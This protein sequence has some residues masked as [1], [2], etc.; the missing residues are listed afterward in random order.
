MLLKGLVLDA[1]THEAIKDVRVE[2]EN[3]QKASI[4]DKNGVYVIPI[5]HLPVKLIFSNMAYEKQ[6]QWIN[7][8][9]FLNV[10]LAMKINYMNE[11]A[12]YS[13]PMVAKL[14]INKKLWALDYEFSGD[15]ILL[16]VKENLVFGK[17][18]LLLINENADSITSTV[19]PNGHEKLIKDCE[20]NIYVIAKYEVSMLSIS[21]NHILLFPPMSMAEYSKTIEPCVESLYGNYYFKELFAENYAINYCVHEKG[22]IKA[23][24]FKTIVD[25][26][27][28][29][30]YRAEQEHLASITDPFDLFVEE[31]YASKILFKPINAPLLSDNKQL[32]VFNFTQDRIE[33]YSLNGK[34]N[35]IVE[36]D[37]HKNKRWGNKILKDEFTGFFYTYY[38]K[39]GKYWVN[40]I[41]LQNGELFESI[42]I[43][44]HIFIDDIKIYH[45][46]L[47]FLYR[48]R[49]SYDNLALYAMKLKII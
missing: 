46:T 26:Q 2:I 5:N 38:E 10:Q 48:D 28:I 39:A 11:I 16:L 29:R 1:N 20:G 30:L 23:R 13:E 42:E 14:E 7:D 21:D 8:L 47:Y 12:I 41:N 17:Y 27:G 34:I 24:L 35:E 49:K 36:I 44:E 4:T 40:K 22:Q 19:L 9:N 15:K 32:Y 45:N 18:S 25:T 43:P 6:E 31:V 33:R 3:S 37:F